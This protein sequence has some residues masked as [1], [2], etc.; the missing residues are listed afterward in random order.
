[1]QIEDAL[2]E[3]YVYCLDTDE[4]I[5]ITWQSNSALEIRK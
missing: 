5:E 1:M 3:E 4:W 2:L